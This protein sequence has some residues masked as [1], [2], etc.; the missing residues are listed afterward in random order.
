[1]LKLFMY[2]FRTKEFRIKTSTEKHLHSPKCVD[3]VSSPK[4][5]LVNG[6]DVGS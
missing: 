3:E 2:K 5:P 6:G 1:M 4:L